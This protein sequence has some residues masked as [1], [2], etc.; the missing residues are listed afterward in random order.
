[1]GVLP[2]C[3]YVC[4][5]YECSHYMPGTCGVQKRALDF[6]EIEL[7]MAATRMALGAEPGSVLYKSNECS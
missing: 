6:L 5:L 1:M 4:K 3:M 7:Q 2:T